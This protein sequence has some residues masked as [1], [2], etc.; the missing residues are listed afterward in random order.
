MS[1]TE[2]RIEAQPVFFFGD[3]GY[4]HLYLVLVTPDGEE[5]V[6]RGYPEGALGT[7]PLVIEDSVA[8]ASS[9]D[10]RPVSDRALYGSRVLD[11]DG[12]AAEDIWDIMRQQARAIE[13]A[14]VPY[15]LFEVNSNSVIASLLHVVGIPLADTLPYPPVSETALTG[16]GSIVDSFDF[17]L[18]G[19]ERD[20]TLHGGARH[21]R[22]SGGGG[23]DVLAGRA[24]SDGLT[25]GE[26]DDFLNGGW[27]HDR[28]TGGSG[29]DRFFHDGHAGHGSDWVLDFDQSEDDRLVFG[30]PATRDQFQVNLATTPGSGDDATA[31][32][33]V[34]W[35]PTGQILWAIADGAA[36]DSILLRIDGQD[37]DLLT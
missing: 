11:L 4:D 37:H 10:Y 36:Q 1:E 5:Q 3:T 22:L 29:Q 23:A 9:R 24:G 27:G 21:D 6:L 32:A 35:R 19:T 26:G 31:E 16:L 13:A 25:G 33:F 18:S 12:R 14:E 15:N 28:L 8:M 20:D 2:I 7:G 30:G 34:I 17:V